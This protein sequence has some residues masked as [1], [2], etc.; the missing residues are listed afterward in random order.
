RRLLWELNDTLKDECFARLRIVVAYAKVGPL[1]RLQHVI[2]NKRRRGFV[3]EA[4]FGIDQQGTSAQ[5]LAFALKYFDV[6]Y[7]TRERDLTFHP[8]VYEFSGEFAGR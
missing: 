5:A 4:I 1:L 7:I 3:F 8:K 6:V 2:E